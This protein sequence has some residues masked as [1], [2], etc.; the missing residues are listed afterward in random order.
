MNNK[1]LEKI[2]KIVNFKLADFKEDY[3]L[4]QLGLDSIK[5]AKIA[6][7]L[8]EELERE[9]S[10]KEMME[11]TPKKLLKLIEDCVKSN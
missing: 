7:I 5:L 4:T 6:S 10:L 2:E 9:L 3:K 1:L 8:E 11:M